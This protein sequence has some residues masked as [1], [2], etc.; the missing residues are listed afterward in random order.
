MVWE[1]PIS[2]EIFI[3]FLLILIQILPKLKSLL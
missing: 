2:P 3:H 1:E